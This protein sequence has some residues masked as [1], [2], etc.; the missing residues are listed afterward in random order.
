MTDPQTPSLPQAEH[1]EKL[2]QE[3]ATLNGHRFIRVQNSPWRM[4][5]FQLARGMAF[6]LGTALGASLLVSLIGWW[7]SQVEFL[8]IIGDWATEILLQMNAH[9]TGAPKP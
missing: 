2:A 5:G 6:G 9:E 7:L 4:L 8:P 1:I 3:L